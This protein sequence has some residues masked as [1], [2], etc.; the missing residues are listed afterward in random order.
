[1]K[2]MLGRIQN[3]GRQAAQLKQAMDKTPARLAEVREV[4]AQTAGQLQQ[5]RRDVQINVAGLRADNDQGVAAL[6]AEILSQAAVIREAGYQIGGVEMEV[7]PVQ[8]L[9][10]LLD[11]VADLPAKQLESLLASQAT[12]PGLHGLLASL[13]KAEELADTLALPH[14]QYRRLRVEVGPEPTIRL[15]WQSPGT[16][17]LPSPSAP[18]SLSAMPAATPTISSLLGSGS[19][20]ERRPASAPSTAGVPPP[21]SPSL[22]STASPAPPAAAEPDHAEQ[23]Q[24]SALDRFKKMPDLGRRAH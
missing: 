2:E 3:L 11:K 10:V 12:R 21:P 15:C 19:Y 7:D 20:F 14:L 8:R 1:M 23:W 17:S 6:L 16:G 18:V 22:E 4:V 13:I 5:L 24:T 9:F